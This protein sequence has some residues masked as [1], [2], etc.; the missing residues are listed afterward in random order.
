MTPA[1]SVI[2]PCHNEVAY[3]PRLLASIETARRRFRGGPESIE[4]IVADNAS[5]DD[6][7]AIAQSAGCRL[8][9][10]A[11][12]RIAA[13]RN[14]GAAI[15]RGD[16]LAF[17]DADSQI[18]P[19]TFNAITAF[20]ARPDVVAGTTGATMERWSLGIAVCYAM[21]IPLV[22]ATTMDV[23]VVFCRR[24]D[25]EEIGGYD[26]TLKFA[27]DIRFLLDLRRVGKRRGA[28]LVRAR[29]AKV[30]ASTRKFDQFGEWHFLGMI[31][32]APWYLLNQRAGDAFAEKYWYRSGR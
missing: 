25:F 13:A 5:T 12:R 11:L 20:L 32:K 10:S 7:A 24:A 30:V 28:R 19:E 6:T 18:H 16:I 26:E 22:W 29:S 14:A 17:I 31:V 2:V 21:M 1:I 23:G 27:E 15:A 9:F 3:L 4:V 8:A